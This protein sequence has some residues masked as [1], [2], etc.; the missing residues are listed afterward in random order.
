MNTL[1]ECN[2]YKSNEKCK[3]VERCQDRKTFADYYSKLFG[4]S[5]AQQWCNQ[6]ILAP[7]FSPANNIRKKR[8]PRTVLGMFVMM[9]RW[10]RPSGQ[11]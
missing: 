5:L 7:L 6:D 1:S 10:Q 8:S 2:A 3:N 11:G 9:R 4:V